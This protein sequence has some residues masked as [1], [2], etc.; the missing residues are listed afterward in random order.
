MMFCLSKGLGAPIGSVLCGP[1]EFI[2]EARRLKI[3]FGGAWRQAGVMAAAGLIALEE[4]P[5]RLHEDHARAGAWPRASPSCCRGRS[6]ST[7]SRPTSCSWTHGR[8]ARRCWRSA[9]GSPP[10][11]CCVTMV[12]GKVRMVTHRGHR[13]R[14]DRRG[15]RR[16]AGESLAD[17][18]PRR[19]ADPMKLFG[20]NGIRGD[21]QARPA[22]QATGEAGGRCCT[23]ARSRS[24]T[25]PNWDLTVDGPGRE[26]VHADLRRAE[27][28]AERRRPRRHALR[29]RLDH[30]GQHV[31]TACRSGRS[32]ELAKPKPEAKWVIAHCEYGY[33]SNLSLE[34]ME[35]D[36]VLVAWA[37]RRR[38]PR[39]PSTAGRS[40]WSCPKRYAW[41]SAK[42]L[43]GPG[44]RRPE[45]A[46]VLGGPRDTTS[47]PSPW[48]RSGTPTRRAR[49]RSSSPS[50]VPVGSRRRIVRRLVA[51]A[52]LTASLVPFASKPAWACSC[53]ALSRPELARFPTPCSPE[54]PP[55][56]RMRRAE[57]ASGS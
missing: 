31:A 18:E 48:P 13:R 20:P 14:R 37:Q 43:R 8:R 19:R 1:A 49:G 4:G 30:A 29:D 36:D 41:K 52:A 55:G 7:R 25:R 33:T 35:D 32:L 42:W 45:Q 26:P 16:V 53:V 10:R 2:R 56:C 28:A 38:G 5:K 9:S 24:S 44:V 12:A 54:R 11:A 39:R 17:V 46:R 47:T 57:R 34:A 6:T 21:R 50:F 51:V 3:L 27:G 15:A 23:T 40:G 22:G